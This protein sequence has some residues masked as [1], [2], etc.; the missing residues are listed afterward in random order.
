MEKIILNPKEII[1]LI[2]VYRSRIAEIEE[3]TS[4]PSIAH[5]INQD[6]K[7]FELKMIEKTLESYQS[8]LPMARVLENSGAV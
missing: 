3:L 8:Q 6:A 7:N 2:K 1:F 5:L 4:N